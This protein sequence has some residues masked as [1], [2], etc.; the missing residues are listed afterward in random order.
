MKKIA[1]I[2]SSGSIGQQTLEVVDELKN[3]EIIALTNNKNHEALNKQIQKYKPKYFNINKKYLEQINHSSNVQQLT[4]EEIAKLEEVD[5]L[6]VASTGITGLMPTIA[7]LEAGKK[8]AIANKEALVIGG[9]FIKKKLDEKKELGAQ[10][11]PI[12]SEHSAIWQCMA[13]ESWE[14]VESLI[15]TASG[16]SLLDRSIEDM[17]TITPAVALKHPNWSMGDKITIDSATLFNKALEVIEA[18]ILFDIP[19]DKIYA[20]IHRESIVHSIVNFIDG[21]SKAQLGH[22][23]MKIPIQYAISYPE[24]ERFGSKDIIKLLNEK[25]LSFEPINQEK[26]PIYQ[27][28]INA[29]KKADGT[30]PALL[31]ADEILISAFLDGKCEFGKIYEVQNKIYNEWQASDQLQIDNVL[32][33]YQWGEIFAKNCLV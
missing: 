26:F 2:G 14:N 30:L 9:P 15:I 31:G 29:A 13:G 8:V 28:V 22:P 6:I 10:L 4:N 25:Q 33:A 3:V 27:L 5:L 18:N 12:D 17:N 23:D 1:I 11:I 20:I 19:F 24:R 32:D 21:S 16:G 7:A